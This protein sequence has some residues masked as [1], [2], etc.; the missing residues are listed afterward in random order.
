M[1][2]AEKAGRMES[3]VYDIE[4]DSWKYVPFEDFDDINN[5]VKSFMVNIY[6]Q[7]HLFRVASNYTKS[8]VFQLKKQ[9]WIEILNPMIDHEFRLQSD[10]LYIFIQNVKTFLGAF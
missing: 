2:I 10:Q 3:L 4:E 7:V 6:G 5:F 9:S 1:V 8:Y